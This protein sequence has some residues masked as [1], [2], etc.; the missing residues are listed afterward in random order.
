MK[1]NLLWRCGWWLSSASSRSGWNRRDQNTVKH[2]N[3]AIPNKRIDK[4]CDLDDLKDGGTCG[5]TNNVVFFFAFI[6]VGVDV[7]VF[8]LIVTAIYLLSL[9]RSSLMID[10]MLFSIWSLHSC[11]LVVYYRT[12]YRVECGVV[13]WWSIMTWSSNGVQFFRCKSFFERAACKTKN[14]NIC[15]SRE[16]VILWNRNRIG[17]KDIL[18]FSYDVIRLFKGQHRDPNTSGVCKMHA[19]HACRHTAAPRRQDSVH[20]AF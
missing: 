10:H 20:P 14:T 19:L 2:W 11:V 3:N 12:V 16:W 17:I 13:W 15:Y 7:V 5:E 1:K 8:V 9:L 4:A 6:P 18:Y